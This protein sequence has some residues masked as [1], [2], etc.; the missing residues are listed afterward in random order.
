MAHAG[1]YGSVVWC[2]GDDIDQNGLSDYAYGRYHL[3][4]YSISYPMDAIKGRQ[5][6][7]WLILK[8]RG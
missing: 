8:F 4:D 3:V 5:S 1:G 2:P 7:S 6:C